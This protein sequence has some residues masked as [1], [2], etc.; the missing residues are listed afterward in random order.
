MK[1]KTGIELFYYHELNNPA[2]IHAQQQLQTQ[3][4]NKLNSKVY[5]KSG[6]PYIDVKNL[7]KVL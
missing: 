2:K 1:T 7:K 6:Q 3:D 4:E 5:T